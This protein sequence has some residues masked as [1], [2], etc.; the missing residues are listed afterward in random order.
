[1]RWP[2][3][4]TVVTALVGVGCVV[5][6]V[7]S[8]LQKGERDRA[9]MVFGVLGGLLGLVGVYLYWRGILRSEEATLT[10]KKGGRTTSS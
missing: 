6:I 2:S 1:M 7:R 5:V 9:R 3:S 10:W 4:E 8:L